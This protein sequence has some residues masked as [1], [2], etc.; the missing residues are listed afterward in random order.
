MLYRTKIQAVSG[1]KI[2][3]DGKWLQCIGNKTFHVGELVYTDGRCVY[4]NLNSS[5]TPLLIIDDD[6]KNVIPLMLGNTVP[7]ANITCCNF[8]R[9]IKQFQSDEAN[10]AFK[11]YAERIKFMINDD[12]KNVLVAKNDINSDDMIEA[13]NIHS[14]DLYTLIYSYKEGEFNEQD[15][16][17][18][19][20]T[21]MKIQ[22]NGETISEIDF[23]FVADETL[24]AC[25]AVPEFWS[26]SFGNVF[27]QYSIRFP[28][29]S[30]IE[31][32][33]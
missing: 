22:K 25:P 18:D 9:T 4:G 19:D 20:E 6:V 30:F 11:N 28:V 24:D 5:Q 23:K 7:A 13:A 33:I 3:A 21:I 29:W 16:G 27:F 14:G 8:E 26:P 12:K 1:T 32:E 31:S 17:H 15:Q 10:Q 2:Y